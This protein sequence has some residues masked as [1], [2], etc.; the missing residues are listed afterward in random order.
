MHYFLGM[1][2]WQGDEE[3]FVSQ[4]KYANKILKKF[5]MERNKT[6]ETPLAGNWRKEDTTLGKV[7]EATIYK[8]LMGSLTYLV[9][10]QPNIF[11][12]I[13]QL[14]QAMVKPTKLY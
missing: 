14:S 6:M 11:F 4:G 2:V 10:T 5:Q 7:L 1:E 3:L 9:N 13:N 12:S 8:H